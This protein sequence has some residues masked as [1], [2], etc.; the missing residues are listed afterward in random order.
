M[1]I[2]AG[3]SLFDALNKSTHLYLVQSPVQCLS[4]AMPE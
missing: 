1:A 4:V 2:H 3:C